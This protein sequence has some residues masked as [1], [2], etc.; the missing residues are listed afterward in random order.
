MLG[1]E[2]VFT[3]AFLSFSGATRAV[4]VDHLSI[5]DRWACFSHPFPPMNEF[6]SKSAYANCVARSSLGMFPHIK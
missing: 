1:L 5:L 3:K 2:T 6:E 4:F